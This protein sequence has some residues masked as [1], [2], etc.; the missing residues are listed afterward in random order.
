MCSS[1]MNSLYRSDILP[2]SSFTQFL[3]T[4]YSFGARGHI[5]HIK[6]KGIFEE[7]FL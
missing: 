2:I 5:S 3:K 7:T 4:S 6:A 1:D